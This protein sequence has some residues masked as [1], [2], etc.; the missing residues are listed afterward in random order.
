MTLTS[1][2]S[3]VLSKDTEKSS[4]NLFLVQ[5][6]CLAG[7]FSDCVSFMSLKKPG[8]FIRHLG[9]TNLILEPRSNPT[10]SSTFLQ[11]ASF[12]VRQDQDTSGHVRFE[13]LNLPSYFISIQDDSTRVLLLRNSGNISSESAS[14]RLIESPMS[15]RRRKRQTPG[16]LHLLDFKKIDICLACLVQF[17]Y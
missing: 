13:A 7:S 4:S 15:T 10:N 12:V 5:R 17:F 6:P 3:L 2:D 11:D 16:K 14:Y 9:P 8:W 1:N